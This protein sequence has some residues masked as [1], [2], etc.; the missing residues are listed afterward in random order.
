MSDI[1][2]CI[3][4]VVHSDARAP[5]STYRVQMHSQFTF[6]DAQKILPYLERL[7]ISDLYSS[8]IFEARPGSQHGYDVIR[9]DRLNPELG[10]DDG[11]SEL[12]CALR[13]ANM[14]LLL[15]IVPNHMGISNNSVWWQ[16]VLENGRASEHATFFDIEWE[17][18]KPDMRG[19]L[20]L[21]ILGKQYGEELED[22]KIQVAFEDGHSR[23]RYYEHIFPIAPRTI[24]LLFPEEDDSKDGVPQSFRDLLKELAHIPPHDTA[25]PNLAIQRRAQLADLRPRLQQ[26]LLSAELQPALKRAEERVNGVEG[27]PESFDLLHALLEIQPYRLAYWRVS[28]EEIN[29]RR[30]FDVNDLVG[31]RMED[32]EAF[33]QTHSLV[34]KLLATQQVTGLR[35]DH[36]DGM[37]NPRQYLI[38]LQLL[39]V[40]SQCAG[41]TA[42]DP[43][44]ENGIE[45]EIREALHGYDWTESRG[46]LYTVVEK[47]LEP[48]EALPREWPVSG[49]TGY[50]FLH[51]VNHVF[52]QPQNETRFDALYTKILGREV[53]PSELIYRSK[54]QV[55]QTSLA[56]E[57]YVLINLLNHLA[58]NDRRA[59][60]FTESIL[61][62]VIRETIACFAVYRTYFDDRGQYTE[63]DIAFIAQAIWRAKYRNPDID[64][65]AFE[66]LQNT[67]LLG[68]PND[69]KYPARLYFALK[70][71][72]LT[73]PVMAKGVEDTAFYVYT[74]FLSANE[75]GSSIK[76]FGISSD[77]F[78]ATNQDRL[79]NTPDTM[80]ATS[81]HDTKR[82]EDVR[83]RLNV[84]SEMPT[85]WSSI[86]RR[87]VRMN[88]RHKGKL[89]DGRI[90]PDANE[91]YLIY[92]TIIGAWPWQME[93]MDDREDFLERV[94]QYCAKALNE[95]KVNLS[96]INPNPAYL[97]AVNNFL[98]AILLPE[99]RARETRFVQTLKAVLPA[100]QLFG[101]VNSLAQVVLKI[102][103]PGVPDFYQGSELWDLSLVDPDNRRPVDYAL[104][105]Q[106]LDGLLELHE[107]EGA[108][109]V[110]SEVLRT[111]HDGRIKL[112]TMHRALC[113]RR[114]LH[115]V[116]RHGEYIPLN[117]EQEK[118]SNAIAFLRQSRSTKRSVL[119]VVPR[120]AC[121]LTHAK[122][123][124]PLA[125]VWDKAVLSIPDQ[126]LREFINVFTGKEIQADETCRLN[127]SDIF[128]DFP[129]AMLVSKA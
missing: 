79:L 6:A 46:P 18:L 8:P 57:V 42:K 119:I 121:S 32:P 82:S 115:S 98:T 38:R 68:D 11:F 10:G 29:Y 41:P 77:L 87:W 39:Y 92:Q 17:P 97:E 28:G 84:L 89:A 122:P 123:H 110:C 56:S 120:F 85:Q 40:A 61:E 58:S 1:K 16:D 52:I 96:W 13:V 95:A 73:G 76:A 15:D 83:N 100:L 60:D 33:A 118:H 12:S 108:A 71:Q 113:T 69:E 49:T 27:K 104:R 62:S 66:F 36:C 65:S 127:L 93:T 37:F 116:F 5:L 7:G 70:F 63:R 128:A 43:V 55:M 44:G 105:Q 25:D 124:L 90:A 102:A 91:E 9:H 50:D 112:W 101:A 31:L 117:V 19:K 99:E 3:D 54:L 103:S 30:F 125:E 4:Q 81:T 22:K 80:L 14:G 126:T 48:R 111:L 75:V 88:A 67:L 129:V 114:E 94:K 20:L 24:P 78:H 2:E 107:R 74:R 35:I 106:T 26:A 64:V 59:R 109:A 86:I 51:L 34:R 23:I 21:P 72:Q 47:V 53:D 45:L